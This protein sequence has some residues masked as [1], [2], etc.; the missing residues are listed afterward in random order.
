[1]SRCG[2]LALAVIPAKAG[3]QASKKIACGDIF[4]VAG[5]R[6]GSP[7]DGSNNINGRGGIAG[8]DAI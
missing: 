2:I 3:I 7:P 4:C 1:M 8:G 5:P 6:R